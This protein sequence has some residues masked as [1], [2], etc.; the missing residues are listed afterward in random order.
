MIINNYQSFC[1]YLKEITKNKVNI[2]NYIVAITEYF[3][4]EGEKLIINKQKVERIISSLTSDILIDDVFK[5]LSREELEMYRTSL[6]HN[7]SNVSRRFKLLKTVTN[8]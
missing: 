4:K 2:I 5:E 7:V 6:V 3:Y 8:C 1:N